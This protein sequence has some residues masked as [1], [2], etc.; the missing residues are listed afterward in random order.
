MT[1]LQAGTKAEIRQFDVTLRVEQ[2]IVWLYVPTD[3]ENR[4]NY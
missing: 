4:A 1:F 2:K 3:E